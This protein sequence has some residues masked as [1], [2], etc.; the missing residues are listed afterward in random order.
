M[1]C[2]SEFCESCMKTSMYKSAGPL[3]EIFVMSARKV[4]LI[5]YTSILAYLVRCQVEANECAIMEILSITNHKADEFLCDLFTG[6]KQMK[7]P[8]S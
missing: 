3:L 6:H 4:D 8:D 1:P 5:L 7:K 2:Q